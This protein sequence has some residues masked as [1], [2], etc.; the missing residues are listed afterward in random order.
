MARKGP[1]PR[2]TCVRCPRRGGGVFCR[3]SREALR[4]L[5]RVKAS[6]VYV[7]GQVVFYEENAPL[8]AYCVF[9]GQ[10]KLFRLG[11]GGKTRIVRIAGPGELI[12]LESVLTRQPYQATAEALEESV[13]CFVDKEALLRMIE[14]SAALGAELAKRLGRDLIRAEVKLHDM[15]ERPAQARIV[16]LLLDFHRAYQSL[17]REG[18]FPMLLPRQM[19]AEAAGVATETA[20]RLLGGLERQRLLVLRGSRVTLLRPE[21]LRR[22][23]GAHA[24]SSGRGVGP[25]F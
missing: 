3:L 23:E 17:G 7:R 10:V 16:S 21:A 8:G 25:S 12:G 22:I 15:T 24:A 9:S 6:N 14:R 4:I 1:G 19:L 13:L 2:L 18:A 11:R 20:I 5:D